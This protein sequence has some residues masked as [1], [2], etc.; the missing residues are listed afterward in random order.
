MA[1]EASS[2]RVN[3]TD[4]QNGIDIRL[5]LALMATIHGRVVGIPG[6]V[7]AQVLLH[8]T[9]PAEETTT[10][11]ALVG[12]DGAFALENVAPGRYLVY[13]QTVPVATQAPATLNGQPVSSVQAVRL[14]A[15]D[16]LHGRT[17]VNVSAANP[18]PITIELAPGRAISGK[19]V[20]DLAQPLP[21]TARPTTITITPAPQ[22]TG[23]PAFNTS[24]QVDVDADGNFTL[25]G[26]RPGRYLL[27]ASGLGTVRSV[28]WNGLDTLDFP[29]EVTTD[30]DVSGVVITLS[31]RVTDVSGAVTDAAGKPLSGCTVIV[32]AADRKFWTPGSRRVVTTK[33]SVDGQYAV[34]GLPAGD[35]R[36]SA[37]D[38]F[39]PTTEMEPNRLQQLTASAT[40]ISLTIGERKVQNLRVSR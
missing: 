15:F 27:R 8:N 25:P 14:T 3:G 2:I 32:A 1:G 19:V 20:L 11:T 6:G 23:L 29:L 22:P 16:R 9:D 17:A 40:A 30:T 35:Y 10:L 39:D 24:P 5:R 12:P 36:L 7:A 37:T 38:D 4:Q 21:G 33:T 28:M 18:P 13:A 34:R 26:I 31:D